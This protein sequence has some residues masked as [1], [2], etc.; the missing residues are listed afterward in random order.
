MDSFL[1]FYFYGICTHRQAQL[2][3]P[4]E[5]DITCP[6][7]TSLSCN[8]SIRAVFSESASL[9]TIAMLALEIGLRC[10]PALKQF[11]G[12]HTISMAPQSISFT[13]SHNATYQG[14]HYEQAMRTFVGCLSD[15]FDISIP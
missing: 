14:P 5:L 8:G 2:A 6:S 13:L 1:F 11:D 15:I 9:S 4:H 12:D 3:Y 10:T 7:D